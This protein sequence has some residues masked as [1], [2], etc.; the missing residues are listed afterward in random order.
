MTGKYLS[1]IVL[2]KRKNVRNKQKSI[3]M[4]ISIQSVTVT[5]ILKILTNLRQGEVFVIGCDYF[6]LVVDGF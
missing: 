6:L 4:S 3:N 2:R 5:I 1:T